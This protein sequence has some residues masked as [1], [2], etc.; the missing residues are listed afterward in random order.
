MSFVNY[1]H[2]I[3]LISSQNVRSYCSAQK[4]LGSE[5]THSDDMEQPSFRKKLK[6]I[7]LTLNDSHTTTPYNKIFVRSQI[8]FS[9]G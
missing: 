7:S 5:H 1:P 8:L 4:I 3:L 9:S 2:L 6:I